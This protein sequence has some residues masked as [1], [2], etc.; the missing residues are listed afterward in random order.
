MLFSF[1]G[2]I[3][4]DWF[5]YHGSEWYKRRLGV[6]GA[7]KNSTFTPAEH[8]YEELILRGLVQRDTCKWWRESGILLGRRGKGKMKKRRSMVLQ[9]E[10]W[11]VGT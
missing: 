3:P 5:K 8:G 4:I 2:P 9:W 6:L 11:K 1:V 10:T 7:G